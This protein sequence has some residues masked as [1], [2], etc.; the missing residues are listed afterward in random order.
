[1]RPILV[2]LV[3]ALSTVAAAADGRQPAYLIL[4]P[5]S[6]RTAFVAE[7]SAPALHRFD[8]VSDRIEYRGSSFVSI[9]R[10]G[11]GKTRA[12]DRRT[13]LGIY[14]VTE[15]LDTSRLH[16]KYGPLAFPLD[17]P[18]AWDRKNGRRGDGIWV[19]GVDPAGGER[20]KHDTDGCL[21]LPND[22]LAEVAAAFRPNE[23]PVVIA[24]EVA[25]VDPV[26]LGGL[27][28]ELVAVVER[29]AGLLEAGDM[30]AWL[31]LYAPG[32]EHWGMNRAEWAAFSLE[33]IGRRD[34]EQVAVDN[35]LLLGD[36]E[37]PGLYL[38]RFRLSVM[39]R[40]DP[41]KTVVTMRRLYWHR[42]SSGALQI[43]AEDAG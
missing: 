36:P 41:A 1:M 22:A 28:R 23:T 24:R 11:V 30:A 43:V 9:G 8:H 2:L 5:E 17:Y 10:D 12:G 26:S 18:T 40:G 33:T 19:H 25:W 42:S 7:T 15:A 37:V 6:V 29:W 21:A 39:E 32:F 31:S 3:L 20:P 4:L 27:R 38:S 13:P 16:E 34:I 35:L 14:F